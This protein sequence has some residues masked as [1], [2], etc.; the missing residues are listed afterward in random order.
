MEH[1][2]T[3]EVIE[4]DNNSVVLQKT[5]KRKP[6]KK[7]E[8]Q[9]L[10]DKLPTA[11]V[12]FFSEEQYERLKEIEKKLIEEMGKNTQQSVFERIYAKVSEFMM[13]R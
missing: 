7:K 8:A 2:P 3:F 10:A 6:K 4:S 12:H 1:N 13:L 9:E 11:R 5:I